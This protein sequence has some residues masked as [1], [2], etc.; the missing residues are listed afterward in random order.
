M[1]RATRCQAGNNFNFDISLYETITLLPL[2]GL[3]RSLLNR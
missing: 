3:P 2:S 1:I